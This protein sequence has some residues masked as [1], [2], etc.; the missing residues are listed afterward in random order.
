[1]TLRGRAGHSS[2]LAPSAAGDAGSPIRA[3]QVGVRGVRGLTPG[4][5][6]SSLR[7][8]SKAVGG[9]NTLKDLRGGPEATRHLH[10]TGESGSDTKEIGLVVRALTVNLFGLPPWPSHFRRN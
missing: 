1:M 5:S 4:I 2:C 7:D 9:A 3:G 10:T 8:F 6:P